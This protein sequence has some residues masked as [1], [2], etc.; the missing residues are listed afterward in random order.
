MA[1]KAVILMAD[2]GHDPTET[3]VAFTRWEA[4]GFDMAIA[5]EHGKIPKCDSLMLYGMT[6]KLLGATKAVV[7]LYHAMEKSSVMNNPLSWTDPAFSLDKY[8]VVFLPGGH[9]KGMQQIID[10]TSL[11]SHLASYFPK[12]RK[13]VDGEKKVMVAICHGVMVLART[14]IPG[15]DKS[16]LHDVKTTTLPA[17]MEGSAFW[18]TRLFLGDYY[19]TYG[20]CGESVEVSVR[21]ALDSPKKQWCGSNGLTPFVVEDEQYNYVSARFPGDAEAMSDKVLKIVGSS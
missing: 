20:A 10:S 9:D 21:S 4:A 19:K 17:F 2:Y 8:D 6:Q 18:G 7:D 14:K 12:T 3:A 5:T 11:H 1:P 15:S 13:N 16:I